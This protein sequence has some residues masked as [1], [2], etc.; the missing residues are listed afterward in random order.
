MTRQVSLLVNDIPISLDYFVE[1][2]IDHTMGGMTE[3]LE[4]T[5][6]IEN[7]NLSIV[8]DDVMLDLNGASVP[9]NPFV[10]KIIR[11][12]TIGMVS[13]LKGIHEISTLRIS[14]TR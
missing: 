11:S 8:G 14:I 6:Q 13:S 1:A 12:T 5:G 4:G 7:L 2:F 10:T 3:A 9:I